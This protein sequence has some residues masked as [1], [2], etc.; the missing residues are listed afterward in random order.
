MSDA[1][2]WLA[3]LQQRFGALIRTPLDRATGNLRADT[4]RYERAICD[5][6]EPGPH[7]GA[8]ERLAVYHR[9][10]WF[11]L[12]TMLQAEYRLTARLVGMWHFNALASRYLAEHPP[13]AYDLQHA[14]HAFVGFVER[15]PR[16]GHA[17]VARDVLCE[18]AQ[19]DAAHA[20]VFLAPEVQLLT[21]AQLS[22]PDLPAR[23]LRLA[24]TVALFRETRPL[25]ALRRTLLTEADDTAVPVPAPLAAPSHWVVFR[26]DEGT[27]LASID[28][29]AHQLFSNLCTMPVG[30]A[31]ARLEASCDDA[32]RAV[33]PT[34]VQH[35]LRESMKVGFW[36]AD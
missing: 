30:D 34:R 26:A 27:Q 23:Q 15:L 25:V 29:L 7:T 28:A 1:P 16:S 22:G 10:Y 21:P 3:A 20:R 19:L 9:Q 12:F 32:T 33:L 14:A 2:D 36:L 13:R 6:I 24:P 35:W 11:R 8:H 17:G 18:A 5:D 4:R 31:L